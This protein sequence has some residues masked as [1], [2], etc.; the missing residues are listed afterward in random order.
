MRKLRLREVIYQVTQQEG[1]VENTDSKVHTQGMGSCWHDEVASHE[2]QGL[3]Y[4]PMCYGHNTSGMI[5]SYHYNANG[6][7]DTRCHSRIKEAGYL[8]FCICSDFFS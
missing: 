5:Q 6:S 8:A 7:A 2:V 3:V 4:G 1:S